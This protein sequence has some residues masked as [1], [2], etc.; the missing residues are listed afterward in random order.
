MSFDVETGPSFDK[1]LKRL[2]KKYPSLRGEVADLATEIG[3][4]PTL[5]TSLGGTLY[6]IQLS[7]KSKRVGKS[8]GA[9]VITV[10]QFTETLVTLL[11]IYDKSERATLS[12]AELSALV[13]EINE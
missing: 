10:V 8:G 5:D 12:E 3:Q 6:K 4:V 2:V 9:R 1:Q 13:A 7:I 11:A